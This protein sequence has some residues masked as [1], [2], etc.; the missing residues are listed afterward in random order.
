MTEISAIGVSSGLVTGK[1]Y[2][3]RRRNYDVPQGRTDDIPGELGRFEEALASIIAETR[4]MVESARGCSPGSA[5]DILDAYLSLLLD[6]VVG[7][8]VRDLIGRSHN[9]A[10]AVKIG[11]GKITSMFEG[12]EDE[13]MRDRAFDI[14]DIQ[15]RLLDRLLGDEPGGGDIPPGSILIAEEL[16]TSD[17]V[18]L[19]ME[20]VAGIITVCGGRNSHASIVARNMD[21]PAVVGAADILNLVSTG[22]DVII[23]GFSGEVCVCPTPEAAKSFGERLERYTREKERQRPGVNIPHET[24]D[25]VQITIG[26]NI[27]SSEEAARALGYGADEIGLFRS[28]FMHDNLSYL[29][30]E[31]TQFRSFRDAASAMGG[32]TVAVRTMDLGAD[33]A[34]FQTHRLREEN[35]ALGYRGIRIQLDHTELLYTQ[36]RAILRAGSFGDIRLMFPMISSVEELRAAKTVLEEVK[37]DLRDDGVPFD[38]KTLVGMMVEVPSAVIMADRLAKECDFFSIGTNDLIQY[39]TAAD[40]T[41]TKVSHLYSHYHPAV[42]RMIRQTV[43]AAENAGIGCGICGECAGDPLLLPALIG[44]GI[45]S[46]STAPRMISQCCYLISGL[47]MPQS[48]EL[49]NRVLSCATTREVKQSL[50]DFAK[51]RNTRRKAPQSPEEVKM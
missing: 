18:K 31:E 6:P 49:A 17:T 40:R 33:K 4:V 7:E 16:A 50:T 48:R 5:A 25:G 41:N 29:P 9:A 19:D 13:Y 3:L 21:I 10:Q 1:A 2:V 14:M 30:D 38:E 47:N 24:A 12:M 37:A 8:G 44:M 27:G 36:L 32:K 46:I 20:R 11:I 15:N 45:T 22:D 42:L 35:P 43:T 51:E 39:T 26:A 23:D 34:F 28:E